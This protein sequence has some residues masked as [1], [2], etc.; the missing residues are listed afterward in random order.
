[1]TFEAEWCANA[2]AGGVVGVG[3]TDQE[4]GVGIDSISA[5]LDLD[6]L[7]AAWRDEEGASDPVVD[8]RET[9]RFFD[10]FEERELEEL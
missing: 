10:E 7:E 2:V 6:L 4:R 1:M 9:G 5:V 3:V 8:T